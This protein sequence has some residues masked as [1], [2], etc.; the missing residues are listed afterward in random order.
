MFGSRIGFMTLDEPTIHLDQNN[1]EH[2]G[3]LMEKLKTLSAE[4][5]LQ[6]LISTHERS[7]ISQLDYTIDLGTGKLNTETTTEE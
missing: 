3:K 6:I 7:I 5:G 1:V 4:T 2:F